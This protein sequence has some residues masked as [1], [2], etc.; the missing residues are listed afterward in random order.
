MKLSFSLSSIAGSVGMFTQSSELL[1][2][3]WRRC[4][5]VVVFCLCWTATC[6][7]VAGY[8]FTGLL[9]AVGALYYL[10]GAYC[11]NRCRIFFAINFD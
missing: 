5:A 2:L 9:W 1:G 4:V 6:W 8:A 3:Y 10:I 7:F 11:A